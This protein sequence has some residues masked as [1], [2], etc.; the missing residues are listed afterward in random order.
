MKIFSR[1]FRSIRMKKKVKYVK[2]TRVLKNYF[3]LD[4]IIDIVTLHLLVFGN[5]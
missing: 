4:E 5:F 3:Y 2:K 1:C